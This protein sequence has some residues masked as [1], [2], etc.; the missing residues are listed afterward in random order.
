MR[1]VIDLS[2][3]IQNEMWGYFELPGLEKIIPPVE[4]EHISSIKKDGFFASKLV[5]STVTGCYVEAG[6]H[7]LEDG[8]KIDEYPVE[9]FVRTAKLIRLP[10]Q[11]PKGLVDDAILRKNAPKIESGDALIIETGWGRM[12]NKPGYVLQCPNL[13]KS[14][15]QWVLDQ[16]I[17]IFAIDVPCIE[18]SWSEDDE[19]EKGSLLGEF[20]KRDV[21]LVAPVVNLDKIKGTAGTLICLPLSVKGVSGAPA[22]VIFIEE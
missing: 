12:W 8:K 1:S 6:S 13:N 18:G 20:F 15:L 16:D 4:I 14:S 19:E 5:I 22:R 10:E 9:R 17:S 11:K 7:M 3:Q 21:L 2:G